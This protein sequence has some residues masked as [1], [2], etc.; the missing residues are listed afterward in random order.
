MD[1]VSKIPRACL[2][3][4]CLYCQQ[5][6]LICQICKEGM[7]PNSA[8][9]QCNALTGEQKP[10]E[11]LSYWDQSSTSVKIRFPTEM[12]FKPN[13]TF[14]LTKIQMQYLVTNNT[15]TLNELD[16]SHV[17]N[18]NTLQI[19]IRPN[20]TLL[21]A[22]MFLDKSEQFGIY[23]TKSKM[24]FVKYPI[25]IDGI[26]IVK[27]TPLARAATSVV[28]TAAIATPLVT[29]AI[30]SFNPMLSVMLDIMFAELEILK[31]YDG[32]AMAYPN[33][34]LKAQYIQGIIP[35]D[36]PNYLQ[37]GGDNP[38]CT[39]TPELSANGV[40][41]LFLDNYGKN[42]IALFGYLCLAVFLYII[43]RVA[44]KC[45]E[46]DSRLIKVIEFVGLRYGFLS[47][48]VKLEGQKFNHTL[49]TVVGLHFRTITFKS[50][51]NIAYMLA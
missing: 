5:N 20:M 7:I 16:S 30:V 26:S 4:D 28:E 51:A 2:L 9:D 17:L 13:L 37:S 15:Y 24:A 36:Y 39:I 42:V 10:L 12:I 6:Y 40:T 38:E 47:L 23:D 8:G 43:I 49:F 34:F 19:T 33:I 14:I 25:I 11:V 31:L 45:A 27:K 48:H 21:N 18:S 29:A 1:L 22:K 44:R 46:P 41:C 50:W 35:L 3:T 32:P